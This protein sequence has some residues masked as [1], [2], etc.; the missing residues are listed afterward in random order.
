MEID[1]PEGDVYLYVA[2]GDLTSKRLGALEIPYHVESS[3]KTKGAHPP[4]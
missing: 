1:L 4:S 2:A 3:K